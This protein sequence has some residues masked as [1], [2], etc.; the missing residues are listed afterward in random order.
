VTQSN[1]S[2]SSEHDVHAL[3]EAVLGDLQ[4]QMPR[5]TFDTWLK[6]TRVVAYEDGLLVIGTQNAFGKDWLENRLKAKIRRTVCSVFGR[7][8]ELRF[9]V[10]RQPDAH[11]DI[12]LLRGVADERPSATES[13][14]VSDL[15]RNGHAMYNPAGRLNPRYTFETFVVGSGNRMAHAAALSVADY[16]AE[17]FNPLVLY[18]G[19]GLGKTHLLH[20]VGHVPA[21]RGARVSV[22]SSEQFTNELISAIRRQTTEEFRDRYRAVDVLLIDDIQF[23]AGKERTQEEIFH[24]FNSL[25]SAN[26]QIIITSDRHPKAFTR[27]EERL[28]SRFEW[29]LTVDLQPPDLETRIAILQSKAEHQPV[30]VPTAVLEMIAHHIE[31]NI[32]ELEGALNRV[33]VY[34]QCMYRPVTQETAA[35]ALANLL[36][37]R[38]DPPNAPTVLEIVADYFKLEL[39]ELLGRSRAQRVARPRQ[40]AMY[41]LRTELNLSFPHIGE[42]VGGRDHSTAVHAHDKISE[43]ISQDDQLRRDV[44]EIKSRMYQRTYH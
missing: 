12:E 25:H 43:L 23:I 41:L 39:D 10:N 17:R 38:P 36:A 34:A 14:E 9:T 8:V 27:L 21:A 31:S 7:S 42:E 16:P 44:M 32:R 33:V 29:G 18:G 24:T 30:P 37:A 2:P 13:D 26:K 3:W 22:V 40:V 6:S 19:V 20:A 28:R 4:L 35:Q 15:G 1:L 11:A 5:S